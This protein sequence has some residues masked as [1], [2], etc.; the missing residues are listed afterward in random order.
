MNLLYKRI[1][2]YY[3]KGG[4]I[5]SERFCI[6]NNIVKIILIHTHIF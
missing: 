4:R 6:S 3:F 2:V 1:I 5:F